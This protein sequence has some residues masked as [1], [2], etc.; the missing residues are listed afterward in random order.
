MCGWSGARRIAQKSRTRMDEQRGMKV[1]TM[2]EIKQGE[3][4]KM[5]EKK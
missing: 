1:Q 5:F 2:T 3:Y 4:A